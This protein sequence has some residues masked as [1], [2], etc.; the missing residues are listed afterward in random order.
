VVS[1]DSGALTPYLVV[2]D[3]R[4]AIDWYVEVFGAVPR[5]E[6]IVMPDGRIGHAEVTVAGSRL[7]LSDEFAELDLLAP[8]ARGGTTVTLH[9][10]VEDPDGTVDRA[11]ARGAVLER[12]VADQGHG[13]TGVIR[14]LSGHRWMV[15]AP[16]E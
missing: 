14:D 4:A 16:E 12:P 8:A 6:P 11:V 10:Q 15:Q 7:M 1:S 5:S 13:R 3:A 2:A 9:L